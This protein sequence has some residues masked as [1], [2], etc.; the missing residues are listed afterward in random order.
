MRSILARNVI[1]VLLVLLLSLLFA[2]SVAAQETPAVEVFGGYTFIHS[3]LGNVVVL[4]E[5]RALAGQAAP[6]PTPKDPAV[7]ANLQGGSGSIAIN[8]NRWFGVVGDFGVSKLS[9]VDA[10]SL[11]SADVNATLFSYLFGPRFS[12]RKHEKVT[13]FAQALF[14]GVRV[15]DISAPGG[16]FAKGENAFAMTVGG[17]FDVKV[18]KNIAIR[19]IQAEYLMTRF[20]DIGSSTGDKGRQNHIRISTGIVFRFGER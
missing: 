4:S 15:G 18:H 7:T 10:G 19:A 3:R 13:P 6:L 5:S 9:K 20:T 12:Y 17:G 14:G 16:N 2:G 8:A 11:G 1:L